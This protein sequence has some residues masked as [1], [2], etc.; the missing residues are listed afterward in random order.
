MQEADGSVKAGVLA[1]AKVKGD[2]LPV[3]GSGATGATGATGG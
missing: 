3:P 1:A 2:A